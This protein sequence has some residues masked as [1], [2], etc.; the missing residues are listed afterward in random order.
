MSVSAILLAAGASRRMRGA[1]KLTEHVRGMPLLRDRALMLLGSGISQL[2]VV[3][4]PAK[5]DRADVIRDVECSQVINADATSG[6]ASSIKCGVSELSS[7]AN[8]AMILPADMPDL[9]SADIDTLLAAHVMTPDRIIRATSSDGVAGSPV[10]FPRALFPRLQALEGDES[11]RTILVQNHEM[12]DLVPLPSTHATLDLDT[13][14][15]WATWR[16]RS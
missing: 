6:M 11:G 9:T 1:D 10:V 5:T 2:V 3:L 4:P 13:P 8:A 7:T 14:E 15:A 16:D 12:I